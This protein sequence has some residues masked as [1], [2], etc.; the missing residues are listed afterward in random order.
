MKEVW[1]RF[2][3]WFSF[4]AKREVIEAEMTPLSWHP[5]KEH[6]V[7]DS[8]MYD[9]GWNPA[10]LRYY[11]RASVAM[12]VKYSNGNYGAKAVA[13][14]G[15]APERI[16]ETARKFLEDLQKAKETLVDREGKVDEETIPADPAISPVREAFRK[17]PDLGSIPR[18]EER[19]RPDPE[20]GRSIPVERPHQVYGNV[21]ESMPRNDAR[22]PL[23]TKAPPPPPPAPV[24]QARV[25]V[26]RGNDS[27]HPNR[28][29][30]AGNVNVHRT[31]DNSGGDLVTGIAI[32]MLLSDDAPASRE[33]HS[34][35]VQPSYSTPEPAYCA[36][37]RED[38]S[39]PSRSDDNDRGSYGGNDDSSSSD[40]S[41]GG[42]CD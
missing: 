19:R 24:A 10:L 36:P 15:Q 27:I 26:T 9:M 7:T 8:T 29:E 20:V 42:S 17:D 13:L 4:G 3:K 37:V 41:G 6:E 11:V 34:S 40:S 30:A 31:P 12:L 23:P 33:D 16:K 35:R 18:V 28:Y 25:H 39:G 5:V 2:R 14:P 1:K 21:Q 38:R 22:K 32:G